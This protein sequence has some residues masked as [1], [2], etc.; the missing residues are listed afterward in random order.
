MEKIQVSRA[1]GDS[2]LQLLLSAF[3]VTLQAKRGVPGVLR[4]ILDLSE[5]LIQAD[6]RVLSGDG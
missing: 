4:G 5:R 6:A 1:S 2:A 3:A